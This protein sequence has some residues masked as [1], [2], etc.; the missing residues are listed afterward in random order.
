MCLVF[1]YLKKWVS[2]IFCSLVAEGDWVS[3]PWKSFLV[4]WHHW[5]GRASFLGAFPMHVTS[6]PPAS[7]QTHR[8]RHIHPSKNILE[9]VRQLKLHLLKV[10]PSL[11]QKYSIRGLLNFLMKCH[12]GA[13]LSGCQVKATTGKNSSEDRKARCY[14]YQHISTYTVTWTW[15][16]F[17]L[18]EKYQ[19][20][21]VPFTAQSHQP[22]VSGMPFTTKPWTGCR[23]LTGRWP[24]T[25]PYWTRFP[26]G[27]PP[28]WSGSCS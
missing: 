16:F 12:Q 17:H 9:A 23:G 24:T 26:L 11:Q 7:L 13:L 28:H 6:P 14:D 19:V 20:L 1:K 10:T 3:E 25:V 21:S 15:E 8:L 4:S 22:R 27:S 5:F 2:S 18:H